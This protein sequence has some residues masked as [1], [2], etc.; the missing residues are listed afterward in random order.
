[1]TKTLTLAKSLL[2]AAGVAV[3]LAPA[4]G[5]AKGEGRG[6]GPRIDF[7]TLD[8]DGNGEVT[9]AE[10]AAAADARF[11]E[12]DTDG[13]GFL[14]KEEISEKAGKRAEK[15]M[16]RMFEHRDADKDGKLSMAE[17]RPDQERMDKRFSRVDADNSGGISKAEFEAAKKDR[18]GRRKPASE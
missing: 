15:R 9:K 17:L 2:L 8:T 12:S 6:H 7:E 5:F 3:V 16:N 13:D 10:M 18:K 1:M 11:A 4:A 14:T